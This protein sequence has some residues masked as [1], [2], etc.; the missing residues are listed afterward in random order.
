MEGVTFWKED[1]SVEE[2]P[3]C[4][5]EFGFFTRRHHCRNCGGIFCGD[6]SS[7]RTRIAQLG[8]EEPVRVCDVC[9]REVYVPLSQKDADIKAWLLMISNNRK[10][11]KRIFQ[12]VPNRLRPTLWPRFSD[13]ADLVEKNPGLYESL[14]KNKDR[15]KYTDHI[16]SD[17]ERT[18]PEHPLFQER[19]GAG[20]KALSHVLESF[21]VLRE[22]IG[23]HQGMNFLAA[24]LLIHMDEENAFWCFVQLMKKYSLE[25]FFTNTTPL[26]DAVLKKFDYWMS[27]L[28]PQL[29]D[30]FK[31]EG[32]AVS[33]VASQWFKTIFSYNFPLEIVF[34]IWDVFLL[35]G[36]DFLIWVGLVTLESCQEQLLLLKAMDTLNFLKKLPEGTFAALSSHLNAQT[37]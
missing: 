7:Q 5:N 2:C 28:L 13:S 3:L 6:C 34:R 4:S 31:D 30:H 10:L 18:F 16:A 8:F 9:A 21:T 15:S 37:K 14:T 12:G 35:E 23:Y 25:G 26:L 24:I 22:E 20:Q 17:I 11:N 29:H 19:D 33:I 32:I 36:T 27:E 1:Y